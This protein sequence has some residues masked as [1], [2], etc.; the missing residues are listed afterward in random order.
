MTTSY[1]SFS[2]TYSTADVASRLGIAM[3]REGND[4]VAAC[5]MHGERSGQSLH[6]YSDP[7]RGAYC[8]GK[9]AKGWDS[10]GLVMAVN[11]CDFPA[12]L[13]FLGERSG[14][15][16]R[17]A[18][19]P[20]VL[21]GWHAGLA[22]AMQAGHER[23]LAD[24]T[25]LA[26]LVAERGLSVE[27]IRHFALGYQP[28]RAWSRQ[29][30]EDGQQHAAWLMPVR[31]QDGQPAL[32]KGRL[33][34]VAGT[35][36]YMPYE[37]GHGALLN[38]CAHVA[39]G[40]VLVVAGDF[41]AVA[42][43]QLGFNAVSV[44]G[45]GN[46]RLEYVPQFAGYKEAVLLFDAGEEEAASKAAMRLAKV[47]PTVRIGDFAATGYK[48][49][50]DLLAHGGGKQE[51]ARVVKAARAVAL[52]PR[53]EAGTEAVTLGGEGGGKGR[54][55]NRERLSDYGNAEW[56]VRSHGN[57]L[58]YVPTWGWLYWDG[59][60]WLRDEADLHIMALAKATVR[61][62]YVEAGA[63]EDDK[64]RGKFLAHVLKSEATNKLEA[65]IKSAR[66]ETSGLA[67]PE[68]FDQDTMLY[69]TASGTIDLRTGKLRA[70]DRADLITKIAPIDFDPEAACP[71]W[72]AFI[73]EIMG[74]DQEMISY[75][76]VAIGYSITGDTSEHAM[77][78][79]HGNGAN[80]K[81]TFV[82]IIRETM[83]D[84]AQTANAE[85]FMSKDRAGGGS[86]ASP[87][88]ARLAGVRFVSSSETEAGRRINESLIK[89][90]VGADKQVA[91]FLNRGDFEFRPQLKL[92][93]ATN[94][95]PGIRGTDEGIWRRVRF[96]PFLVQIPVERRDRKLLEKLRTELPG[97]LG[98]AVQG[99]LLWQQHGLG[100]PT[101]IAEA[102]AAYRDEMD[103]LGA[104]LSDRCYTEADGSA[105][106]GMQ[107]DAASLYATY[108]EWAEENGEQP[109][110]ARTLGIALAER[111]FVPVRTN[112]KRLWKGLGMKA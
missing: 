33:W 105:A 60:R 20:K 58:K 89:G 96:V 38:W 19:T 69:N 104:F 36:K 70:H 21:R 47:V 46:L 84:Y 39:D 10:P 27:T 73:A 51:V 92:W 93:M 3:Q 40:T 2:D 106:K 1:D 110:K 55:G 79:L 28:P 98:W 86:A 71:L 25:L 16:T 53:A 61:A 101:A 9:C 18:P 11:R 72:R 80:G 87:D 24:P 74:D 62:M 85:T 82:E 49:A 91:R 8:F 15:P 81:S 90:I 66:S 34:G 4:Y 107:V 83:G 45:Q 94:H 63:I 59:T 26:K 78:I 75:L 65:M 12:A 95:K 44:A 22:V 23:L 32:L 52:P 76:Q 37:A 109:M 88:V 67:E 14:S 99:C 50:S 102:T 68:D 54:T 77:H 30:H 56:L 29:Q 42:L 5:P 41:D 100:E 103:N 112:S 97:I 108:V 57:N 31:A 43:W 35:G 6:L 7:G 48:D 64:E 13:K 111:G 17:P